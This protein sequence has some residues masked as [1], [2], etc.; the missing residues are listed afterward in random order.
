MQLWRGHRDC[1]KNYAT[2]SYGCFEISNE[3]SIIDCIKCHFIELYLCFNCLI[4]AVLKC[5]VQYRGVI[6]GEGNKLCFYH[7]N[8]DVKYCI[9][10]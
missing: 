1:S 10:C 3:Q 9:N 2:L 7:S 4:T 8:T 6:F 5:A